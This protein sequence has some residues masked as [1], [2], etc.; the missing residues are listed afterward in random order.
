MRL[1][2]NVSK[3]SLETGCLLCLLLILSVRDFGGGGLRADKTAN[4]VP[5]CS[6]LCRF[7]NLCVE[8]IVK[9]VQHV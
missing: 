9:I 1:D 4:P 7:K 3:I 8:D 5:K 2:Y 6:R